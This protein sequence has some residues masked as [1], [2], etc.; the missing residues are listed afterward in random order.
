LQVETCCFEP[1]EK[2][3]GSASTSLV[4]EKALFW[5]VGIVSGYKQTL[6]FEN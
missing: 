3:R 4:V 6:G 1:L 2:Q 5:G